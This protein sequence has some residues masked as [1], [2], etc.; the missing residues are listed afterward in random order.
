MARKISCYLIL[1]LF[2]LF[3]TAYAGEKLDP[4]SADFTV[5]PNSSSVW[6]DISVTIDFHIHNP[7]QGRLVGSKFICMEDIDSVTV[8][9]GQGHKLPFTIKKYPRKRVMW[10]YAS[11][12]QGT[13]RA[14]IS[15]VMRNAVKREGG[16]YLINID[17]IGGWNRQVLNV[18][19][20]I[21]LPDKISEKDILDIYRAAN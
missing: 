7:G 17:W 12:K 5:I 3:V 20:S 2:S 11:A 4:F 14:K 10:E 15:F 18:T 16:K 19:Y 21:I 6:S 8:T 9:D 1:F 13:R